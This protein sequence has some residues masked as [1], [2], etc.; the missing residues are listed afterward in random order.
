MNTVEMVL[1]IVLGVAFLILLTLAIIIAFTIVRI[2]QNLHRISAKA[3]VAPDNLSSTLKMVAKRVAPMAATT[4]ISMVLKK[5][6]SKKTKE[7]E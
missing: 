3:E 2:M 6:T 7:D 5:F 1:L 4:I